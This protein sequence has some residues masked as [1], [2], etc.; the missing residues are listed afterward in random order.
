MVYSMHDTKNSNTKMTK[1]KTIAGF[2]IFLHI[3]DLSWEDEGEAQYIFLS[4]FERFTRGLAIKLGRRFGR[5][6]KGFKKAH[7]DVLRLRGRD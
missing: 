6:E 1:E 5:T 7:I 3:I 2:T 4:E